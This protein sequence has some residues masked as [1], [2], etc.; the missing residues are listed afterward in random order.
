[1][2]SKVLPI[3]ELEFQFAPGEDPPMVKVVHLPGLYN[4]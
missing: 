4:T 2:C 1:M 3:A